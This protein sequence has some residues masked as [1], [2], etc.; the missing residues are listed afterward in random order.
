MHWR[1]IAVEAR[2]K[3]EYYLGAETKLRAAV[4]IR[5]HCYAVSVS[6]AQF[7]KTVLNNLPLLS[8]LA[9]V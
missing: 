1:S 5:V 9:L 3:P 8:V 7:A 2:P 4:R 6:V